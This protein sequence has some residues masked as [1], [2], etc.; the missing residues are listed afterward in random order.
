MFNCLN[1]LVNL[2]TLMLFRVHFGCTFVRWFLNNICYKEKL[3]EITP[4]QGKK[5]V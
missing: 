4:Y 5:F 1:N 3:V 2:Y